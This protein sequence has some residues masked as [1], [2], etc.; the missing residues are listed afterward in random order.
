MLQTDAGIVRSVDVKYV[1]ISNIEQQSIV[2]Y[3]DGL[4]PLTITGIAA[5]EFVWM[6]KPSVLEGKKLTWHKNAWVMH[7]L[8]AHPIM[9]LLA[10]VRAYSWAIWI[11]DVTI[12]KPIG[13][14]E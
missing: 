5:L 1:D 13:V 8:V 7:N 4:P 10:F 14:K 9:Q 12:P 11:H 6:L 2:A 3:V